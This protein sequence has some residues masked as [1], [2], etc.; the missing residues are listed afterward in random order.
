MLGSERCSRQ[1]VT[2]S[3]TT[4]C[5]VELHALSTI[6]INDIDAALRAALVFMV[7]VICLYAAT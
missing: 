6:Q 5:S 2:I 1:D 7:F 4:R 3:S